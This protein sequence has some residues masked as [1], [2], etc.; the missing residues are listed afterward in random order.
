ML[1]CQTGSR[2]FCIL[3]YLHLDIIQIFVGWL[4]SY[5][6]NFRIQ[7]ELLDVLYFCCVQ[8]FG[9]EIEVGFNVNFSTQRLAHCGVFSNTFYLDLLKK[10]INILICNMTGYSDSC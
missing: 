8:Y 9:L 2:F 5:F 10:S 1:H 4:P 7:E 3:F 6:C